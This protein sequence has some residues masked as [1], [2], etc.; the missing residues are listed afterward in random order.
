MT[1]QVT[2]REKLKDRSRL[3]CPGLFRIYFRSYQG[4]GM[5]G[6]GSAHL[7]HDNSMIRMEDCHIHAEDRDLV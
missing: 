5:P 1:M 7:I 4:F 6:R 3:T 2:A